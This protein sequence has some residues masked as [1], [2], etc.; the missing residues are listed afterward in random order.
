MAVIPIIIIYV[1]IF[2]FINNEL[3]YIRR[4]K[5]MKLFNG[6]VSRTLQDI[7][8]KNSRQFKQMVSKSIFIQTKEN[9]Y[10]MEEEKGIEY[11][12]KR[13][14]IIYMITFFFVILVFF[15]QNNF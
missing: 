14:G 6:G 3:S 5:R 10:Y 15:I 11:A 9:K 8:I 2:Y 12:R 13:R 7:S 4:F 1:V